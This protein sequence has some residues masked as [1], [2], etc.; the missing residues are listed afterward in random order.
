MKIKEK[1]ER[2]DFIS[3][4]LITNKNRFVA[5]NDVIRIKIE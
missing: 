1:K 5:N 3:D 4:W 2:E